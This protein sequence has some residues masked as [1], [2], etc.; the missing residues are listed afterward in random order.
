MR[1]LKA[2]AATIVLA[3]LTLGVPLGL[4][5]GYGNPTDGL[6][7]GLVT[8]TTITDVLVLL[9]W[10]VWAQMTLCFTIETINQIR[11]R[12]GH[13]STVTLPAIGPQ[14]DLARILIG[15]ILAVG[16]VGSSTSIGASRATAAAAAPPVAA[17]SHTAA[18]AIKDEAT[19][20]PSTR[21]VIVRPGDSLWKLAEIHLGDGTLWRVIADLNHGRQ[22]GGGVV[23]TTAILESGLQP[24]WHLLIP[25][26]ETVDRH[27]VEPG[28]SLSE[29]ALEAT[30][31]ATN[32]PN[33]YAGN[34]ALIGPDPNLIYAGED[35]AIPHHSHESGQPAPT[36][37]SPS[38]MEP[39][40]RLNT[41]RTDD[42]SPGVDHLAP[43]PDRRRQADTQHSPSASEM[44]TV[45]PWLVGSLLLTGAILAAHLRLRLRERRCDRF[46]QRR[47]GRAISVPS[48]ELA[49]LE[50]TINTVGG[51]HASALEFLDLELRRLGQTQTM[52]GAAVPALAATELTDQYVTL[53]LTEPAPLPAP[54]N[55]VGG[56][57]LR[58]TTPLT[59]PVSDVDPFDKPAPYPLLATIGHDLQGHWWLLN[60]EQLGVLTITGDPERCADLMRYIAAEL[61]VASWA[62]DAR[63]DLL[64]IGT[65]LEGLDPKLHLHASDEDAT[66]IRDAVNRARTMI[67]RS[68]HAHTTA[69]T[70]RVNP[71]DDE[72]WEAQLLVSASDVH[73]DVQDRLASI[74]ELI[75]SGRDGCATAVVHTVPELSK[76]GIVLDVDGAGTVHIDKVGLTLTASQ[77]PS[78]DAAG[79]TD[80]YRRA[81]D[82]TDA[83][84]PVD[85]DASFGWQ[86]HT[87]AA[88]NLR[89]DHTIDRAAPARGLETTTLLTG[90]DADYLDRAATIEDDLETL[91]PQVTA[92]I[93]AT[94]RDADPNLDDDLTDWI[95]QSN[96]RPRLKLLGQVKAVA[97][98]HHL[99]QVSERRGYYTEL[100]AFLW[101]HSKQGATLAQIRSAF[102]TMSEGRLRTDLATLRGW[103]GDNAHTGQPL[104]PAA[105][106][107]PARAHH[108]TNVYQLDC[109]PGGLIVDAD[110]LRRL[111]ASAQAS[112]GATGIARITTA[113]VELVDGQ[114]FSGLREG[115]WSWLLDEGDRIDEHMVVA[116][117]DMAHIAT[118]HYLAVGD[119]AN[120]RVTADIG[121]L[122]APY[123]ETMRLD[124]VAVKEAEGDH[125]QAAALLNTS[126]LNRCDDGLPPL[127]LSERTRRILKNR[128]WEQAG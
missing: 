104:L 4:I 32:W 79:I 36:G 77:L 74:V 91:S 42:I 116:I 119:P 62:R 71:P 45:A 127:D 54:W 124:L 48:L 15:A 89:E 67:E 90:P 46:R 10:A 27:V 70:A 102:P 39:S 8:D 34:R 110:L 21:E 35:L 128:G 25:N 41:D 80:V 24:G 100:L 7:Q 20:S 11:N 30:G 120:A 97:Y 65:E 2:L 88:G 72:V 76:G 47:P 31:S 50:R 75:G 114:P 87:D 49:P 125:H 94:V 121:L 57:Q 64:G 5:L 1:Y 29:I 23:A 59:T 19:A 51:P 101:T 9:T 69:P 111:R 92:G 26:R 63:I 93:C 40:T 37:G 58:W 117:S 73:E 83:P 14:A 108:H 105:N 61:A 60:L 22:L 68:G 84:V 66:A 17:L 118:S 122:A 98:G 52:H 126:V 103:L 6:S 109:G 16:I 18:A 112:G 106:Q 123:E 113:L 13:P 56:D 85:D 3:G 33:I 115:G 82:L 53:H 12:H 95:H 86:G 44:L 107:A 28:E 78:A 43:P 99:E 55:P 81:A 38:S 96:R